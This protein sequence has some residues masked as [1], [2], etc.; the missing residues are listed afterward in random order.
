MVS[1]WTRCDIHVFIYLVQNHYLVLQKAFPLQRR[2]CMYFFFLA[3]HTAHDKTI[4]AQ[5][6]LPGIG[7]RQGQKAFEDRVCRSEHGLFLWLMWDKCMV[8]AIAIGSFLL[9]RFSGLFRAGKSH[10]AVKRSY[11]NIT[12]CGHACS[13]FPMHYFEKA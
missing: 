12:V 1:Q 11:Q 2:R 8:M 5:L 3:S 4:I 10:L 9:W 7:S 13:Q 6:L